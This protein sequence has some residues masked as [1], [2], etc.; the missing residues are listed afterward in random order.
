MIK[1][2]EQIIIATTLLSR[3]PMPNM[4]H[5][6]A[7]LKNLAWA[8]PIVGLILSSIYVV[9]IISSVYLPFELPILLLSIIIVMISIFITGALHFDGLADIS[10]GFWGGYDKKHRLEIMQDS[11]IGTFGTISIIISLML[12]V[13]ILN[14]INDLFLISVFLI[15]SSILSRGI[16]GI[17]Q[18][19]NQQAKKTGLLNYVSKENKIKYNILQILFILIFTSAIII[20]LTNITILLKL[21][22]VSFV[23][24]GLLSLLYRKKIGGING[25]CLGASQVISEIIILLTLYGINQ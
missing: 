24:W 14:E 3:I 20:H 2:I 17:I 21:L 10:D 9:F 12:Y 8:Y 18:L 5:G 11:N 1:L 16:M 22:I 7:K 15:I 25:D 4:K 6:N 23:V 19:T 13:V